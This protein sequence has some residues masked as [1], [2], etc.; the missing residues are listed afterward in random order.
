MKNDQKPSISAIEAVAV[1]P[2]ESR[3][4]L[5]RRAA[6][7]LALRNAG[8]MTVQPID[9]ALPRRKHCSRCGV[10]VFEA[11]PTKSALPADKPWI[12]EGD[13]CMA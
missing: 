9:P 3:D 6:A 12:I 5:W 13:M 1:R 8:R 10:V 11:T 4:Y 2:P 7:Q